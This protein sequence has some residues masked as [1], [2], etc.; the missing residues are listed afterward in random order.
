MHPSVYPPSE[1]S[2]LL[3][4][5]LEKELTSG[6]GKKALD[7]GTGSGII[8]NFL[9][10]RGFYVVAVDINPHAIEY[11]RKN[12]EGIDFRV[13][14]L[15]SNV[16]EKFD[17]I[18]FNTPY[19]PGKAKSIEERAWCSDNGDIQRRFFGDLPKHINKEGV[20]YLLL[21]SL[22]PYHIPEIF[23]YKIIGKK[24][25]FFEEIFVV[26]IKF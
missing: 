2:F 1:D 3:L 8:A 16:P 25:L 26:K 17:V 20:C 18:V 12:Y 22:T 11:C 15:F 9:K 24:R 7:M 21:S 6:F 10:E 14:D 13:S 5:I 4:N 23:E 19:L